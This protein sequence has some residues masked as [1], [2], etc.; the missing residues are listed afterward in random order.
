ME[1]N[2]GR[3]SSYAWRSIWKAKSILKEGLLWRI[4][5][6]SSIKI[7]EDSWIPSISPSNLHPP[8][9]GVPSDTRVSN[10]IDQDCGWWNIQKLEELFTEGEVKHICSIAICPGQQMDQLVWGVQRTEFPLYAVLTT[11]RGKFW[12]GKR[13]PAQLPSPTET[14]GEPFGV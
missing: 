4:G 11:W 13:V 9:I 12:R 1:S 7:W 14:S 8:P 3:N 10:L 6:G 2:L 5:D